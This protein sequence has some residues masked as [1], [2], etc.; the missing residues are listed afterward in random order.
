MHHA[1][2]T[3][4]VITVGVFAARQ[5][6]MIGRACR[7]LAITLRRHLPA[8]ICIVVCFDDANLKLLVI[9]PQTR[10]DDRRRTGD[11]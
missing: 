1:L 7:R 10:L 2:T 4:C 5:T 6:I 8:G 9:W 3:A 11:R